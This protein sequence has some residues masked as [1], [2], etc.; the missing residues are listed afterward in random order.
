MKSKTFVSSD[1]ETLAATVV[2]LQCDDQRHWLGTFDTADI[3]PSAFDVVC[4]WFGRMRS[5]MNFPEIESREA[6]EFIGSPMNIVSC[7]VKRDT[8]I[9][10]ECQDTRENDEVVMAKATAENPHLM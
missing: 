4:W 6:T 3:A 8:R 1:Y 5:E 2:E 9:V 10:L 7:A